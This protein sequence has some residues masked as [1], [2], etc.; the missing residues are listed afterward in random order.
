MKYFFTLLLCLFVITDADCAIRALGSSEYDAKKSHSK[1]KKPENI[2]TMP[3]VNLKGTN[4]TLLCN[5][6]GFTLKKCP[7]GYAPVLPC[8][9]NNKFFKDCCPQDYRYNA[10]TCIERGLEPSPETCLGFHAC[11]PPKKEEQ[12]Q[13]DNKKKATY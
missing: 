3:V 13:S 11:R 8:P 4:T 12:K 2:G 1:N 5:K 7:S 10:N 9:E 6:N